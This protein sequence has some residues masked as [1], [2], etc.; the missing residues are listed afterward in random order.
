MT[1]KIVI[2][3]ML[4]ASVGSRSA[5]QKGTAVPAAQSCELTDGDYE[6]YAAIFHG[7]GGPEDPEEA[8]AG[9]E[10]ILTNKTVSPSN[11]VTSHAGWGF[12][13]KSKAAPQ[14]ETVG[15]FDTKVRTSC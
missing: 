13:S 12:R 9:K 8:W 10:L 2:V 1:W 4:A 7:L 11:E 6:V 14:K 5:Q 3:L 15:D